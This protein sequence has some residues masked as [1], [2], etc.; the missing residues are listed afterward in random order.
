MNKNDVYVVTTAFPFVPAKLNLAHFSSTYI[1]ADIIYRYLK[2]FNYKAIQVNATDV[3]SFFASKD[4]ISIDEKQITEFN[5]K[6]NELYKLMHID[7][8]NYMLTSDCIHTKYT[9]AVIRKL[10]E[11]KQLLTKESYSYFC[12]KCNG[13]L[14]HKIVESREL[15]ICPYCGNNHFVK[16]FSKHW[17]LKLKDKK[18]EL[19]FIIDD[20]ILQEDV[21]KFL[22]SQLENIEDWDFTRDNKFGISFPLDERLTLYLWFESLVGYYS[23]ILKFGLKDSE[24]NFIHFLGKNIIYYHGIVWPVI[25]KYAIS[26]NVKIALSVR[27]F[28]NEKESDND[29]L[30]IEEDIQKYDADYLRFY[31][32]YKVTDNIKDFKFTHENFI[33]VINRILIKKIVNLNYRVYCLLKKISTIPSNDENINYFD[34]EIKQIEEKVKTNEVNGIVKVIIDTVNKYNKILSDPLKKV[35]LDK[36]KVI[37]LAELSAFINISLSAI[38]PCFVNK[39]NI[40]EDYVFQ[41]YKDI[42]SVGRKKIKNELSKIKIME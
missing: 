18:E 12:E 19:R 36:N 5:S 14:P 6:Y 2:L 30:N 27:G 24:I 10:Y 9:Q 13:F 15:E 4:G 28:W 39:I 17:W 7:Y 31:I 35:V 22:Y 16:T 25:L 29:L 1:P 11:S 40:F 42:T 38:M 8:D 33:E 37:E 41:S 32:A 20:M 34:K 3:H 21:E 23:L 26:N